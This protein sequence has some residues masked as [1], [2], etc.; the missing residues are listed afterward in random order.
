MTKTLTQEQKGKMLARLSN[1]PCG[2]I[3]CNDCPLERIDKRC[4]INRLMKLVED[5]PIKPNKE[6]CPHCNQ[7][8][9]S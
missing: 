8:I 4:E 6:I 5:T 1:V 2:E 7:E 9:K 3:N